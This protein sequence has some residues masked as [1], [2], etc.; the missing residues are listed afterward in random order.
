MVDDADYPCSETFQKYFKNA[1]P[2]GKKLDLSLNDTL[3]KDPE[4][5][6]LVLHIAGLDRQ[7]AVQKPKKGGIRLR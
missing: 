6:K 1:P 3:W 4:F 7:K 2:E 5:R